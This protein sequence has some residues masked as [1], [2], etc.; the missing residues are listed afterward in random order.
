MCTD[1]NESGN[2]EDNEENDDDDDTETLVEMQLIGLDAQMFPRRLVSF[3]ARPT[4]RSHS[5][6]LIH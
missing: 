1:T 3:L 2:R 6:N 4:S 5:T